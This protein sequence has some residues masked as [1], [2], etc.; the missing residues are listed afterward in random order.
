MQARRDP[1]RTVACGRVNF[2][3]HR[4]EEHGFKNVL[5]TGMKLRPD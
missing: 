2:F 4:R 1:V 3:K 5:G